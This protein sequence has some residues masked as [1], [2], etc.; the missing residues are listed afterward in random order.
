MTRT[1]REWS[2]VVDSLKDAYGRLER[3]YAGDM[4]L[5]PQ[6]VELDG[7]G[8]RLRWRLKGTRSEKRAALHRGMRDHSRVDAARSLWRAKRVP[9]RPD[10]FRDFA[11]LADARPRRILAFPQ[12]SGLIRG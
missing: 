6:V 3:S 2:R 4:L 8:K 7:D 11:N 5:V 9:P 12:K 1:S 10:L